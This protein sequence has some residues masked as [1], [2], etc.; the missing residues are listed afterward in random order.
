LVET[1]PLFQR[2]SVPKGASSKPEHTEVFLTTVKA[3]LSAAQAAYAKTR[4]VAG[5]YARDAQKYNAANCAGATKKKYVRSAKT[6]QEF[7]MVVT[8]GIDAR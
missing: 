6:R 8:K 2:R 4:L 7:A 1:A 5:R 3:G